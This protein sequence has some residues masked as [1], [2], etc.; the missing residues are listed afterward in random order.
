MRLITITTGSL[1]DLFH[2]DTF[3]RPGGSNAPIYRTQQA[4][5]WER[6][7][8]NIP[9]R[10]DWR[11]E[12]PGWSVVF[13]GHD[14]TDTNTFGITWIDNVDLRFELVNETTTVKKPFSAQ[15]TSVSDNGRY[16]EVDKTF[17][18]AALAISDDD[19]PATH[20]M[21]VELMLVVILD[22]M[23]LIQYSIQMN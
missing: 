3:V 18:Q 12:G 10:D 9:V 14:M 11:L 23:F 19:N 6:V 21:L 5:V 20:I 8:L 22:L 15:I 7:E 17:N 2:Q 1:Q 16:I 13:E 4:N